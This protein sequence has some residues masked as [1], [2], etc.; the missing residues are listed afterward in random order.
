MNPEMALLF[1]ALQFGLAGAMILAN[2][3]FARQRVRIAPV[4]TARI[5]RSR[6]HFQQQDPGGQDT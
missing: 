6:R 1:I 4:N 3:R 5:V 2:K